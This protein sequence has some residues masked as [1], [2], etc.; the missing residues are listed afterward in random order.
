MNSSK[1]RTEALK[2]AVTHRFD[3]FYFWKKLLLDLSQLNPQ[4]T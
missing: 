2:R 4:R 3:L 1:I